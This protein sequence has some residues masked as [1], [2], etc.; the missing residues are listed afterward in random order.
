MTARPDRAH[1]VAAWV[2]E[3]LITPGMCRSCNAAAPVLAG[4][5]LSCPSGCDLEGAYRRSATLNASLL[6]LKQRQA[7]PN[8]PTLPAVRSVGD[9]LSDPRISEPTTFVIP[10]LVEAGAVTLLSGAPKAGKST[11]VSQLAADF[12]AGRPAPNGAPMGPG[13]VLW[14]AIDE[15][16]K[17]MAMRLPA[18]APDEDG[19]LVV[20]RDGGTITP[21]IFT[22]LL[23]QEDPALVI[24][25]TLSQCASDNSIKP[26]DAESV[27]PF[28]KALVSAVQARPQCGALFLYHAPHHAQRAS[29][30]VQWGAVVDATIVLRRPAARILR[31]GESADDVTDDDAR[32]DGRRILEGVTRWA[33]EMRLQL[34]FRDGRYVIGSSEAPLIDRV[35]WLL[36]SREPGTGRTSAAAIAKE[37]RARDASVADVVRTLIDRGE[38]RYTGTGGKRYL[39]PTSSMSLYTGS[40]AEASGRAGERMREEEESTGDSTSSRVQTPM[41]ALGKRYSPAPDGPSLDAI[42]ADGPPLEEQEYGWLEDLS[43]KAAPLE[44][45]A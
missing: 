36:S 31:A 9:I 23:E 7:L 10:D 18:L 43:V 24:I 40:G 35:R 27:A 20:S 8:A 42:A 26:N 17:R 28:I 38:L 16:V 4:G 45:A 44:D 14:F 12:S 22:A 41:I 21:D 34:S 1:W 37:L 5:L 39:E 2:R 11:F 3:N 6:Q 30:S 19:F 25:D 13:R 29:G 15:P 33:G 32:E